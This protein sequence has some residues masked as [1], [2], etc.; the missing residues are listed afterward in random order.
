MKSKKIKI[1]VKD[2]ELNALEDFLM[3]EF[4][5]KEDEEKAS[6][7]CLMLWCRLVRKYDK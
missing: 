1:R 7:R 6:K 2:K 3:I 5:N 4:N